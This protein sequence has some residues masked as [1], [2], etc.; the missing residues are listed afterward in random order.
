MKVV[1]ESLSSEGFAKLEVSVGDTPT[2]SVMKKFAPPISE[3]RP[4]NF[5]FYDL[6][7]LNLGCCEEDGISMTVA[8]PVISKSSQRNELVI[9]GGGASLSKEYYVSQGRR[10]YGLIALPEEMN[11]T[12]SIDDVFVA[13]V[14]QEHGRIIGPAKFVNDIKIGDVLMVLPVHACQTALLHKEYL[15]NEGEIINSYYPSLS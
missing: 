11:R 15:T 12:S 2:C 14:T 9:Y 13:S 1:Q 5:V 4:G 10:V 3:I 8:C 6:T 7:Q